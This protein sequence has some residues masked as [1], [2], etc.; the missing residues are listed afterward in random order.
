[1]NT[2]AL[3]LDSSDI[4]ELVSSIANNVNKRYATKTNATQT[5]AGLMSPEDKTKLDGIAAGSNNYTHPTTPG[6]KHIPA[7]GSSGQILKWSADGTAK[8]ENEH[9]FISDNDIQIIVDSAF[10]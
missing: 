9:N 6:N 5:V 7:G 10:N 8:W 2:K 1:M 4:I 3:M